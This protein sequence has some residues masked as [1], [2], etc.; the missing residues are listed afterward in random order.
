MLSNTRLLAGKTALVTGGTAGIGQAIAYLYAE[1]GASVSIFGTN[2]Q[3]AQQTIAEMEQRRVD[4]D[5]KFIYYMVDVSLTVAVDEAIQKLL[6]S[7]GKIDVLV[8]NAGITR[9]NLLMKMS[10]LDWDSVM[11]INLKSIYNVCKS[12][13]RPMMK[14]RS[15]TIINISSVIG[16]TGNAGQAN[17]AASKAGMIGFTKS[18]AKE[19]SSRHIRANCIAPGYIETSMTDS[20]SA[21]LKQAILA[22]IPLG[23]IGSA[24][25]IAYAAL[26]LGSDLSSYVTGQ[27]LTVDG[28]MVV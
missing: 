28:G 6:A 23:R 15:G 18:I 10:E 8:N 13:T 14:A 4:P 1:Q 26:F 12:L 2:E 19:L 16:L 21:E 17:Y 22:K 11:D 27:V 25:D 7:F 5:Q 24:I 3:R 20:L 9:D